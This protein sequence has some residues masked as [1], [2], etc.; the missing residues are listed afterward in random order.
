MFLVLFCF[1]SCCFSGYSPS[2]KGSHC[3]RNLRQ[4]VTLHPQSRSSDECCCSA[5]FLYFSY[6]KTY[7]MLGFRVHISV[8]VNP[9]QKAPHRHAQR[10]AVLVIQDSGLT[11]KTLILKI[12]ESINI[13]WELLEEATPEA[14]APFFL[15]VSS[16][17]DIYIIGASHF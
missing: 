6:P 9:I 13:P 4:L 3:S 12:I 17:F 16:S 1:V 8:F 11:I 15:I 5:Y 7:S 14:R 10:L 2:Q